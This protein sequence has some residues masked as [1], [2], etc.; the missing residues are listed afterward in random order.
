MKRLITAVLLTMMWA[1]TWADSPLT[2]THFAKDYND[3][4]MVQLALELS[5]ESDTNIPV[6]MLNFLTDTKSPVDVRLAVI[7]AISWNFNGK[8]SGEQLYEYL[9]KR[10]KTKNAAQIAKKADA[11]TLAVYAYA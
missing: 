10:Y 11:G 7:N 6:S 8:T 2:S 1:L 9:S 4:P 5:N 3:H